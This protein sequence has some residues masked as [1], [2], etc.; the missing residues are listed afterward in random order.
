MTEFSTNLM[1]IYMKICFCNW[2]LV[3]IVEALCINAQSCEFDA[4][5]SEFDSDPCPLIP[6]TLTVQAVCRPPVFAHIIGVVQLV[7]VGRNALT[8]G[9]GKESLLIRVAIAR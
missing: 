4:S 3:V 5:S 6:K 1:L 8:N 2:Y 9:V 7:G